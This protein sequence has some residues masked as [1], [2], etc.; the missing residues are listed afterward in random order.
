MPS[1]NG[2]FI[3]VYASQKISRCGNPT[4]QENR[5]KFIRRMQPSLEVGHRGGT[6]RHRPA[7]PPGTLA[8][9]AHSLIYSPNLKRSARDIPRVFDTYSSLY[10]HKTN[11]ESCSGTLSKGGIMTEGFYITIVASMMMPE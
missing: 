5:S 3:H 1:A 2:Y 6:T 10:I 11:L 7:S 9:D 8:R 4:I